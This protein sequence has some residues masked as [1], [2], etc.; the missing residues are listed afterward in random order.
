MLPKPHTAPLNKILGQFMVYSGVPLPIPNHVTIMHHALDL[1][2]DMVITSGYINSIFLQ[3]WFYRTT[4]RSHRWHHSWPSV[5]LYLL[6]FFVHLPWN[7]K[8]RGWSTHPS[9]AALRGTLMHADHTDVLALAI[10]THLKK[11]KQKQ[12]HKILTEWTPVASKSV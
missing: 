1:F 4:V 3:L 12:S 9:T 7:N 10:E 8:A 2:P 6:M 11:T 5:A